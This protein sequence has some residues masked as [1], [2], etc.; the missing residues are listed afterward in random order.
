MDP[1]PEP[2]LSLD[3]AAEIMAESHTGVVKANTN[4][5]KELTNELVESQEVFLEKIAAENRSFAPMNG[6]DHQRIRLVFNRVPSYQKKAQDLS[7][8]MKVL[9]QRVF[10]MKIK[11][12]ELLQQKAAEEKLQQQ[13]QAT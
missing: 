13:Q 9:S 7:K 4:R 3:E 2:A 5:V 10:K 6:K 12:R 8:R 1:G 11:A